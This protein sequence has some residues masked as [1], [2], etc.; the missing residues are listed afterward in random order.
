MGKRVELTRERGETRI[1]IWAEIKDG[2]D[3][4]LSGQDMGQAAVDYC[5]A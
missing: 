3:L 2:G 1:H 4:L 5:G